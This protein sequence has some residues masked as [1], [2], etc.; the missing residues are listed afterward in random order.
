MINMPENN[1][2]MNELKK[3]LSMGNI[4]GLK[5]TLAVIKDSQ[6]LNAVFLQDNTLLTTA[7]L[8]HKKSKSMLKELVRSGVNPYELTDAGGTFF[9]ITQN[10]KSLNKKIVKWHQKFEKTEGKAGKVTEAFEALSFE[11]RE[12]ELPPMS[13]DEDTSSSHEKHRP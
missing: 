9:Q 4:R 1:T 7:Y 6:E 2:T 11:D 3:A 10:N 8:A 12:S 5:N 13:S